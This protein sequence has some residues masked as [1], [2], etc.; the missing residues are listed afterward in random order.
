MSCSLD[1]A[2]DEL[3]QTIADMLYTMKPGEVSQFLL[4][5]GYWLLRR[6]HQVGPDLTPPMGAEV[7]LTIRLHTVHQGKDV[8]KL[9]DIERLEIAQ[10]HK[11]QGSEMFKSAHYRSAA[12]CYS[13]SV[14]FLLAVD[15]DVP[16][17]VEVLEDHEKE[18]LSLKTIA[19]SNLAA[20]QLKL[21]QYQ[22]V[23]RNC[24]MVL[25]ID[26]TSLKSWYRRA[27]AQLAMN[28]FEAARSDV[29]RARE[30][31]PSNQ[32]VGELLKEVEARETAHRAK[33]KD[34]LKAMFR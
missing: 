27:K 33:Y 13:K 4:H 29:S 28:D 30:I 5:N 31:D 23:V 15:P 14:Q 12:I 26:P 25:E 20:C 18:I 16:L 2:S 10:R 21:E 8:W 22:H 11:E 34:A 17:E 7:V 32:A 6:S 24:S 3:S 9:T 1:Q 19:L